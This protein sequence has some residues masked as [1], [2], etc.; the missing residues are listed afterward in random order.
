M[1]LNEHP[2]RDVS[3]TAGAT[4]VSELQQ[5]GTDDKVPAYL[6]QIYRDLLQSTCPLFGSLPPVNVSSLLLFFLLLTRENVD[7]DPWTMDDD[8][9]LPFL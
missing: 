9:D 3:H 7:I 4:A 5:G 1:L 6:C 2:G 8:D